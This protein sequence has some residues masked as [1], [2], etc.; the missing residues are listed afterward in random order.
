M[1][2]AIWTSSLLPIMKKTAS[3]SSIVRIV[4]TSSNAHE[5]TP[6]DTKFASLDELNRDLGPNPQ[7]GRS[8]L[9]AILYSRYLAKHLTS[10]NPN[11]LIN[12]IHPG[13]VD[14]KM[15]REDIHEPFPLGGYAMSVAMEPFKKDQFKGCVSTMFAA[16]K[17]DKSGEYICPPATAESGSAL[18][19]DEELGENLMRLTREIVKEKTGQDLILEDY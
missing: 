11:I 8:K 18:A 16:T 14:T 6:D 13:I 15:S 9:A 3:P 10:S 7:Y 2:H 17:T 4:N 1:G 12:A 19:Q 5:M